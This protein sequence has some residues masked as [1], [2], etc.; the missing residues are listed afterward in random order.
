MKNVIL[1]FFLIISCVI[2]VNAQISLGQIDDFESSTNGW[3]RG[4]IVEE[5]LEIVADASGSLGKIVTFNQS[6]WSGDYISSGV[7]MI[8]MKV[9]NFSNVDLQMRL[10]IGNQASANSGSWFATVN[11]ISVPVGSENML[12]EF[13]ISEEYFTQVL[14]STSYEDV[15]SNVATLRILHS[16]NPAAH[17]DAIVATIRLDDIEAVSVSSVLNN[18]ID[19]STLIYPN[20]VSD[21][22]HFNLESRKDFSI[23]IFDIT[24]SKVM[25]VKSLSE[26]NSIDITKLES[27]L[28]IVVIESDEDRVSRRIM[29]Q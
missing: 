25:S 11:A 15:F 17:G 27:G 26:N 19:N 16:E 14:G 10:A 28:Y 4:N 3:L 7:E 18:N 5:Q 12:I 20:P 8:R 21:I 9:S 2:N 13:N 29:V 1:I 24:G 22:L 23:Y 6:R